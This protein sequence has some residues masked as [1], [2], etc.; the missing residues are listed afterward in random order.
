MAP[1]ACSGEPESN[2]VGGYDPARATYGGKVKG[3]VLDKERS[4]ATV[5][6][7]DFV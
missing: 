4:G 5:V 3:E 1:L 6:S 7:R 2:A